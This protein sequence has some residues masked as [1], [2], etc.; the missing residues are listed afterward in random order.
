MHNPTTLWSLHGFDAPADPMPTRVLVI[1]AGMAGLVAARLLHDSGFAVTVLEARER[2][3]GRTWTA[4][5]LGVHCDL[6]GS[7]IHGADTNPLTN[8]CRRLGV[9]LLYT[10]SR[11][12]RVYLDGQAVEN[13]PLLRRAWRGMSRA[14]AAM[15]RADLQLRMARWRRRSRSRSL[16]SVIEP[17]LNDPR[18]PLVDRRV[19]AGYVATMEGVEGAPCDA[20]DFNH[21]FPR[22]S[23]I[24]NAMP[25]G[26]YRRLV[27][28]A[29]GP[30][31]VALST[32]VQTLRHGGDEV[33]AQ[34]A[35]G[36]FRGDAV[37]VTTPVGLLQQNTIHFDPLLSARKR[38]AIRRIGYGGNGVLNKIYLRFP[39]RF[40]PRDVQRMKVLP[41][42][43]E[44]RGAFT[45]WFDMEGIVGAPVL[46]SFSNGLLAAR[47]DREEDDDT[48]CRL[49]MASLRRMFGPRVPEPEGYTVTRWLSDPWA[50]GSYSYSAVGASAEDRRIY[51][52]PEHA[53][54]YFAGEATH[55][56]EY[57]T[58]HAALLS[59]YAAATAIFRHFTG[60]EPITDHLPFLAGEA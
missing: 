29:A 3:G 27:D 33:V 8:W 57:G 56:E 22:E 4:D 31:H 41:A 54:L 45:A 18:I 34:C 51:A 26:G 43:V 20:M 36:E 11:P 1:G 15:V 59:G 19:L 52:E 28:D 9:K 35:N 46:L 39:E 2:L 14:G 40:W 50:R 21:W 10:P 47:L 53:R 60:R 48:I 38:A 37:V 55:P 44:E 5:R 23:R 32:P 24:V 58:V 13:R 7:W 6:G 16:A 30:L 17:V 25:A 12:H 49:A 42:T